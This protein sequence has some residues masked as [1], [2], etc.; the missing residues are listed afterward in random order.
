MTS[1]A[2]KIGNLSLR[3][4]LGLGAAAL[5]AGTLL[6]ALLLWSG[7]NAVAQRLDAAVQSERRIARYGT[8]SQ[9]AANFLIVATEA[10]QRGQPADIRQQRIAPVAA[11][12]HAT[13]RDLQSDVE[14]AVADS[15]AL[16]LDAQ[17]RFG[18]Q[19]LGIAR[20]EALL[21]ATLAGLEGDSTDVAQLRGQIDT[22]AANF[23]P[24]LAQA[25]SAEGQFRRT[26]LAGIANLRQRLV[27]FAAMIAVLTVVLAVLFY[28]GLI[29][30][31]FRR[32]ER[33]GDAAR[34]IAQADFAFALPET[35]RDEIS[36]LTRE[37]NRMAAALAARQRQVDQEAARLTDTIAARTKDLRA[38][39][40]RLAQV[41]DNR[42][43]FFADV[44][45][46]LRTPLTVIMME[47]Q[48]GQ[49]DPGDAVAAFAT[50]EGR[51]GRLN[52]RI[53]DLLR[54]ARSETGELALDPQMVPLHDLIAVTAEDVRA[55]LANADMVLTQPDPPELVL[56]CDPNWTRQVLVSLLRNAI[57]HAQGGKYIALSVAQEDGDIVIAV[58]DNG[59]GISEDLQTRLFSRFTQGG[60]GAGL[61]FG[62][63][64][65]LVQWVVTA[66]GG[67]V[68]VS[69]PVPRAQALGDAPGTRVSIHL[70]GATS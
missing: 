4:R 68:R 18:T 25:V 47:A 5:G 31:Q 35:G 11:Q 41:D 12:L 22:F 46:E 29:R 10:V 51:A 43:R 48:I 40:A 61:G 14:A 66:Q 6:I 54:I 33:L 28:L 69:S 32:L 9:Q 39:N 70:P 59:P 1:I 53:D 21:N 50:I 26:I 55:E 60:A 2:E 44:S 42:R 64:L 63:G 24:L 17:S 57:R 56:R 30:P 13:F 19:S 38:A 16:G 49:K 62:L 45:H 36:L 27:R 65:A 7:M 58:T 8:V 15:T 23:D 67:Q 37:T 20:M 34:R 52:R 3:A